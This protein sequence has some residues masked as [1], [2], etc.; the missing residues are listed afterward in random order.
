LIIPHNDWRITANDSANG[1]A[2]YFSVEDATAG[3]RLL[4]LEAGARANALFVDDSGRV[5]LGTSTPAED[6]HIL[7]GDTPTIRL[8]QSG[9]GWS[10]QAWDVAG[11]EANF[12]I[13][14]VTHGSLLP[15]RIKAGAPTNTL[16]LSENG[17]V[18]IGTNTPTSFLEVVTP[19]GTTANLSVIQTNGPEVFLSAAAG[20][21]V[22]GTTTN[23]PLSFWVSNALKMKLKS[24][25]SL[26]ME[27]GATCT[28]AGVWTDASSI[29]YKENIRKLTT[30]Q[31]V[32]TLEGL[33]PVIYNYK[34]DKDDECVGF[35]AEEV[36]VLVATKNR[37]GM[38]PMDVTAVLTKVTQEQQKTISRLEK[39]INALENALENLL[40]KK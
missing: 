3:R 32:E 31:A 20:A 33:N 38:S 9:G 37:K 35:I 2:N 19:G 18:G 22:I 13:R 15:F 34:V 11:N 17:K 29:E 7:Y 25:D 23:H 1:G 39:K 26:E 40:K 10:P 4:T 36:P 5:G 6:L 14:D 12:F 27:N 28:A 21:G 16:Y 30:E 24:D 8:N